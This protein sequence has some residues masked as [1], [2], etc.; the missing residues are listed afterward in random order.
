[1]VKIENYIV[2]D[3]IIQ[4]IE[5]LKGL[6][7]VNPGAEVNR[8]CKP[9]AIGVRSQ[10]LVDVMGKLEELLKIVIPN[11]CYIFRDSD[12]ITELTIWEA[13]E[14]LIKKSKHAKQ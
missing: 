10:I 8:E 9:G 1:M 4:E 5:K 14:K 3:V 13:A 2:E 7:G 11:N 12:G 6:F